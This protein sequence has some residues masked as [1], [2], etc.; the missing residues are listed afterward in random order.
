MKIK[1][2]SLLAFLISFSTLADFKECSITNGQLMFCGGWAQ[3][4]S[5][6]VLQYDGSY[7]DCRIVNGQPFSCGIW[8]QKSDYP[9]LQ[10]DGSYNSCSITNGTVMFCR[11]W[12][13]G[14]AIIDNN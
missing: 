2:F 7:H 9:V 12:F 4:N 6:P 1:I 3:A 5:V 11:G 10:S 14:K 13:Q 8:S